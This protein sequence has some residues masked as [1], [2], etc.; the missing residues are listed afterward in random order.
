[1]EEDQVPVYKEPFV[2]G[3]TCV[4]LLVLAAGGLRWKKQRGRKEVNK[5]RDEQGE[6]DSEDEE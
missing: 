6:Q 1:M 3:G 5:R 2:V 4:I